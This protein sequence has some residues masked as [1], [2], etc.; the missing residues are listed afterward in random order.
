MAQQQKLQQHEQQQTNYQ[1]Q[2]KQQQQTKEP[3][4]GG[5]DNSPPHPP[6]DHTVL[7]ALS[8]AGLARQLTNLADI[9]HDEI[10]RDAM[11]TKSSEIIAR[12]TDI[13]RLK[14]EILYITVPPDWEPPNMLEPCPSCSHMRSKK[15]RA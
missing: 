14:P 4:R 3:S 15:E 2:Q 5:G 9:E 7:I 1:Q 13:A 8:I 11:R 6:P 10:K 12:A